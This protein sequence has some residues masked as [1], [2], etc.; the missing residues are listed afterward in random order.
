MKCDLTSAIAAVPSGRPLVITD[1]DGVLLQF[2]GCFGRWL[3]ERGLYLDLTSYQL[4][5]GIRRLDDNSQILDVECIALVDEYR[6]DLDDLDAVEGACEALAELSQVASV[7]VLSNVNA[8]QAKA[9]LRNF[10]RLGIGYP[11][12]ANDCGA[13]YLADKGAAVRALAAHARAQT[14]FID[15]IPSNLADV[16]KAAP[17]VTLV[18]VV[19][20]EPLRVLLG[21][22]FPAHCHAKDWR[23]VQSFIL[24]RL[25]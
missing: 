3:A 24:E 10:A 12:I 9:R 1:A 25:P 2:T 20:S 18:H 21:T 19:E 16:A 11:L 14:F 17:D 13:G 22:G 15:D 6:E 23:E 8:I 5:G 7:V 4:E